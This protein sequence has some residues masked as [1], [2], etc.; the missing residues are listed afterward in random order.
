MK[1]PLRSTTSETANGAETNKFRFRCDYI[2]SGKG[3][4]EMTLYEIDNE[5]MACMTVDEETG[6]VTFDEERVASL[7]MLREQKIENIAC[8]IKNLNAEAEA[9]KAEK[10]AFAKRQ[11][12][13]EAKAERLKN[14]LSY[15]LQGE[16]FTSARCAVSWRAS[17]RV[18]IIDEERFFSDDENE[19]YWKVK[20]EA[21]KTKIKAAI[22]T[23]AEIPGAAL[24]PVKNIQVR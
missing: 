18:D 4:Q 9:L 8:F 20:R 16:K 10:Q 21:D 22:K 6:E 2:T 17:E 24:T 3:K 5:I 1:K 7:S 19:E 11:Q 23:G 12:A 15:A 14:Y 13:A